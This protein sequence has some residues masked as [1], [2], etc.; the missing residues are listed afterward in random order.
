MRISRNQSSRTI[1]A[2]L[3]PEGGIAVL[4]VNKTGANSVKG[5]VLTTD[6]TVANAVRKIVVDIPNPIGV[7]YESG[8]PDGQ[9]AWVV[10]SGL[11]EVYFIGST[12]AGQFARGFLTTDGGSYVAGQ[13]LAEVLPIAPFASDK[14]FYEIGH[15]TES[16]TGAGLA[17]CI[18]HFN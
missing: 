12:T 10:L 15:V 13:A 6:S 4:M 16:R 3:T 14:H 1:R 7:F 9:D 11:A 5:E 18:L 8:V 2:K 17:K